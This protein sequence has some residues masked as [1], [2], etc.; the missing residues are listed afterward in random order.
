MSQVEIGRTSGSI[1]DLV[2]DTLVNADDHGRTLLR[3]AWLSGLT[4]ELRQARRAAGLSQ[5]ELASRLGTTQSAI[6]RLEHDRDGRFTL[7]RLIDYAL[8]VG[9][10]PYELEL[11]PFE[12]I[13]DYA[14][15]NPEAP[16]DAVRVWMHYLPGEMN[17]ETISPEP[18][19][20]PAPAAAEPQ[21][22]AIQNGTPQS[23]VRW[24]A[25]SLV[26]MNVAA[27]EDDCAMPSPLAA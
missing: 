25:V 3:R 10:F 14:V 7:Q 22:P 13:H 23:A 18:I 2:R 26:D 11:A 12:R 16:R 24:R 5:Q 6:A 9:Y 15:A 27:S 17:A 19:E 1:A 4:R 8:A 20:T 21:T